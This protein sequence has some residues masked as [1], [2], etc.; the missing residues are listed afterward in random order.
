MTLVE[1]QDYMAQLMEWRLKINNLELR[2]SRTLDNDIKVMVLLDIAPI[3]IRKTLQL[4]VERITTTFE[5]LIQRI[6]DC[7]GE[8][9]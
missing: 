9:P 1:N 7:R 2:S 3:G 5:V 8:C 4:E 6:V